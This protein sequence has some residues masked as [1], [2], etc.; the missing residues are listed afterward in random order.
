MKRT[1][2]IPDEYANALDNYLK[3]HPEET[4]SSI[5]QEAIQKKLAQKDISKFLALAGLIQDAPCNAA[6]H[7]EDYDMR[8]S[9]EKPWNNWFEIYLMVQALPQWQGNLEAILFS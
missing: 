9:K 7:A 5:M 6:N 2:Y 8:N 4:L 1:V 3:E